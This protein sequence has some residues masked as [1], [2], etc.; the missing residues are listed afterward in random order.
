MNRRFVFLLWA[1]LLPVCAVVAQN[2]T[3]SGF[4]RD[5][6]T[7]ESLIGATIYIDNLQTGTTTNAYGFYSISIARGEK[8]IRYSYTG[9]NQHEIDFFLT[10]DT[11]ITIELEPVIQL[12]EVQVSASHANSSVQST[13]MGT[14][15]MPM[16]KIQELPN[17]LGEADVLKAIQL[18][19]GVQA[20]TEGTSGFYVRGGGPDQNLLLLD[21]VPVYNAN[22]LFGFFSVFNPDAINHIELVKGGFPARYGGRLSSVLDI[23]MKEG[24]M[25]DF[26]ATGSIGILASRLT[27][28]APIKKDKTSFILSGRRFY[29][30]YLLQPLFRVSNGDRNQKSGFYFADINAKV[31]H[32]IS[33]RDR[34]FLSV[35]SG[36]DRFYQNR[37]PLQYL[38]EGEIYE[39]SGKSHMGWGNITTAMRW[40]HQFNGKL[41]GS[42]TLTYSNYNFYV[43]QN[44]KDFTIEKE[45]V[46]TSKSTQEYLSGIKDISARY[47]LDYIPGTN[48]YVKAGGGVT[49]YVFSPGASVRSSQM[50]NVPQEAQNIG[51][52]DV[53]ATSAF[54]YVE[55]DVEINQKLKV[56]AGLRVSLFNPE[57]K[58]YFSLEPRVS[59]RYLLAEKFALKASYGRMNQH[60]H[61]LT[62]S[63]IGLPTDLWVPATR[64][65]PVM[66][67][68]QYAT[69]ATWSLSGMYQ[70]SLEAYYKTMNN[71]IEYSEGASFLSNYTNWE[72]KVESGKAWSYGTEVFLEKRTGIVT[73]WIGYTWAKSERQFPTI[74]KGEI[75]PYKYDRRHDVSFV[76]NYKFEKSWNISLTWV[77]GTG[78]AVT[79]PTVEYLGISLDGINEFP[80]Q[81]FERRNQFRAAPYHRLDVGF[82]HVKKIKWGERTWS[83]GLYN[84]YNRVNPLY[85]MITQDQN[86]N[87]VLERTSMFPILPSVNYSFKFGK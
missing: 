78:N 86:G 73:G 7:G 47:D 14:M 13:R 62:N 11:I 19:P 27:I 10:S 22:H 57:G 29:L 52:D 37:N 6:S 50:D 72:S 76:M 28:E 49:R 20:G 26:R 36:N 2:A 3:L 35:Y 66:N 63:N 25:K 18:L 44:I 31:N 43:N 68:S 48:H 30:D 60:I 55:D 41:F 58:N 24:N 70:L 33:P 71:V 64:N 21:G 17:F 87:K 42:S 56:N 8:I 15:E 40:T 4:V 45:K 5:A 83:F 82:N 12:R 39:K 23:R 65:V 51:H 59:L 61:L 34:I 32:I 85:Y 1:I 75:F 9:Y 46:I 16:S 38:Y 53:P 77:Y 80:Q 67:S 81:S 74:N 69:G 54:V 79:M 84:A